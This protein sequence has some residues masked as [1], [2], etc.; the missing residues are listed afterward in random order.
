MS[1]PSDLPKTQFFI[2]FNVQCSNGEGSNGEPEPRKGEMNQSLKPHNTPETPTNPGLKLCFQ[3]P[4]IGSSV[5]G[6]FLF[7]STFNPKDPEDFHGEKIV[8]PFPIIDP[9]HLQRHGF[10]GQELDLGEILQRG[11][12]KSYVSTIKWRTV[13]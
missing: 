6:V 11:P 3:G 4:Q 10:S 9:L 8:F 7:L 12:V 1:L 2:T 5:C 13:V